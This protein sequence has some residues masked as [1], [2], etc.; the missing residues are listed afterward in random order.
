MKNIFI[1]YD[2]KTLKRIRSIALICTSI[3]DIAIARSDNSKIL[4]NW[5]TEYERL[6]YNAHL[7]YKYTE[8]IS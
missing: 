3:L 8:R 1:T 2:Q 5:L 6:D 4:N 7:I